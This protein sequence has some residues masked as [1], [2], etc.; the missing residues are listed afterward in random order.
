MR[1]IFTSLKSVVAAVVIASMALA[2][3]CSYDDTNIRQEVDQVKK[4]LA[5]LTERVA[6]LET[7][8]QSEVENLQALIDGQVVVVDVITDD[9]GNQ[10]IKLSNGKEI[11]VLA[12]TEV[13][14]CTCDPLEYRVVDGVLEVSADGENWVAV[15]GVAAECVV[16]N[17]VL[18]GDNTATITLANGEEFTVLKAELIECEATRSQVYVMADA[19]KA[20]P[21]SINDAVVEINIMNQPLGWSATVEEAAS[22]LA[23]GGKNYVLNIN[24]PSQAFVAAGYAA[25]EGIVSVHFNTAAGACKVL[26]V[27]VNLAEI[28]LDV[29]S[30]GNIT[31]TNTVAM[32]QTNYW[33]EKFV[34]FADF[35]V[36]VM[37]K[38]LYDT[39]G[40][41]ALVNDAGE[42]GDFNSAAVTQR[43]TGLW[44]VADIREYEEGVYEK[45]VLTFT[46][47][48]LGQAF[49]PTYNFEIGGE[50]IIFVALE[51]ELLNYYQIPILKNAVMATYKKVLVE[52]ALV[53]GSETWNDATYHVSLAGFQNFLIGWMS[54]AEV[55]MYMSYGLGSTLEE[56]L[57]Q[58]IEAYGVMSSGAILAGDYIDQD[59]K[60][61]EL[62]SMSLMQ[63]APTL[64]TDTEYYFYIYPF[65]AATEME[66]YQHKLIPENIYYFGSFSTAALV[67]GNFDANAQF[68]VLAHEEK[69]ISV[70]VTLAED[71][72][73]V[74][75]NWYDAPFMDPEE[76]VATIMGDEYYTT[77]V[78]LDETKSFVAE[79]YDYYGLNN[80]TY[81]GMVAINANGEYVYVEQEFTY[82]EPVLPQVALTSFE[83]LGRS[84][85]LDEDDS[86]SGGDYVY[87]LVAEDGSEFTLGLFYSYANTDGSILEGTYT[88]CTNQLNAMYSSWSGFVIVSDTYYSDSVLT[89]TA[90]QI[91]WKIKGVVEYVYTKDAQGGDEPEEPEQ[92]EEPKNPSEV[93]YNYAYTYGDWDDCTIYVIS[94]DESYAI[95]MNFYGIIPYD[96]GYIPEGTYDFGS[97][98]GAVYTGGYS[99]LY[100]YATQSASWIYA[101]TVA[102]SEVD[103]KYRLVINAQYGDT[104]KELS[105]TYEGTIDGIILPSEYVEPEPEPEPEPVANAVNPVRAEYDNKFDLYEYNGGDAEYAFWLYDENNNYV[106]VIHRFGSHTGWD[107]VY[108]AKLVKDG[109]ES[110]ATSIQTQKPN[111]WNC[112]AGELYFVVIAA[113]ENGEAVEIQAQLPA[114]E[115]NY[116]G[117]G[118]TYAPGSENP[119]AGEG[120][121]EPTE[122]EETVYVELAPYDWAKTFGTWGASNEYEIVWFDQDGH[123]INIDFLVNPIVEGTYTLTSGLS[124]MY[125][126]Y[127]GI[128]MTSCTVVVTDAGDGQLAFDV[129]FKAQIEGV[130]T[131]YHFTWVGDP[132]TL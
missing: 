67:A 7:K 84:Y 44:N 8:L 94:E 48:Q 76:A 47:D 37:P 3:S 112:N 118:S 92:P 51:S 78:D 75:Y 69:E 109:V 34:D 126:K 132:S 1:K 115:V 31:I 95:V 103:G 88:Y 6:A 11:T 14:G 61:S 114:V 5:A 131:D 90:D 119:G 85:D 111:T 43:G 81:L 42:W 62:A 20:L 73:S 65:N 108:E 36:G 93:V 32:E 18:N 12:P 39:Y 97:F 4:D 58:Y 25:K 55:E 66:F 17:I 120:G 24:G 9:D 30:A 80:P 82:V 45:E 130:F 27:N 87:S 110:A 89:V 19:T 128:G 104:M 33:G 13:E 2:T 125:T 98:Y 107:D 52:A 53:E 10:T 59:I 83:F 64:A 116:L 91:I 101:G 102:V 63:W 23:A 77:F 28:T 121:D 29:D 70:N 35:W 129:T 15:N 122:P 79:D 86:T 71:V 16:A 68:E 41:Q 21:F 49:W 127:R 46:A 100:D 96:K 74:A 117:E 40:D 56:I 26:S 123:S 22:T 99:Y 124:G 113:F 38:S 60:L 54:A 106:E 50:Y 57:P 105:A 72:V